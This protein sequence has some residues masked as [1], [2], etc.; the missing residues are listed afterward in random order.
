[1]LT[2]GATSLVG[3]HFV[4]HTVHQ[5][6]AAGRSDPRL[7]G[8]QVTHFD[9]VDLTQPEDAAKLVRSRSE[10]VVVNFAALTNVDQ[11]ERERQE[12]PRVEGKAWTVNALTPGAISR[13]ARTTGKWFIQI[14][15]DFVFDGKSGPYDEM[16]FRSP[17]SPEVSWY[18]WTKGE[19]E[20][21]ALAQ[22][23]D[24]TIIRI[25]YPYRL[26]FAPKLDFARWIL[27]KHRAG[28]LPPLYGNQ[29]ITPTW[30]PDVTRVVD[31]LIQRPRRGIFHVA[32]PVLT[33]PFEF[34]RAIL[35]RV[36]GRAPFLVESELSLPS[37]GSGL[38]PR[39]IHGGLIS[40]RTTDLGLSF[41]SWSEGIGRWPANDE[42]R[43]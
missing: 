39:P 27:E 18:G 3:S 19:G 12:G 21:L 5:V 35:T 9:R 11:V 29:R 38:A 2:F 1:M 30:I 41:T 26:H 7:Q 24:L 15:T 43:R 34:G 31:T 20:R 14:S 36:E 13:A 23:S 17:I 33:T 8:V 42:G 10:P 16:A 40:R 4:A 32:S 22:N 28:T 37:R 6:A 25:S